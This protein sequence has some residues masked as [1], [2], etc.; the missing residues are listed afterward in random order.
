MIRTEASAVQKLQV[1]RRS[2]VLLPEREYLRL[3]RGAQGGLMDAVEFARASIGRD[4][5]RKRAKTGLTLAETAR[6]AGIRLET[7][8]RLENGRGNPTVQTV[9]RILG[10]LGEKA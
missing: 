7:L 5:R 6:K 4:L 10:A 8:S 3:I 1:G 9:R 2:F